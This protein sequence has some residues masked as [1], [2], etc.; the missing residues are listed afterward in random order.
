MIILTI[1]LVLLALLGAPLFT[2]LAAGGLLA[3]EAADV[4][5]DI[6]IIEMHRLTA[7]PTMISIPLFILAG[8]LM[9]S[10]GA[11]HRLVRFFNAAFGWLPGGL[12]FVAIG[13]CAF[14][15][16]FSG[17]SGVTILAM[18]GLLY[19]MLIDQGYRYR[20]TNGLL[21]TSGSL[22]LLFPPSLAIIFFAIIAGISVEDMFLAGI[23]PGILLMLLLAIYSF[24]DSGHFNLP[25]QHFDFNK[26]MAAMKGCFWELL[27]PG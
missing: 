5:P 23:L 7:S 3:S 27:M 15:T 2:V 13:V 1:S 20:F 14:F 16:A 22:G 10:G 8:V 24:Y 12:S 26:V 9:A 18:G 6:L 19:P 25:V 21:T 4:S 11:A 17:A